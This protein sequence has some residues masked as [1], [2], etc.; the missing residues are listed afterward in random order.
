LQHESGEFFGQ[1]L[2]SSHTIVA[3]KLGFWLACHQVM[4]SDYKGMKQSV[5]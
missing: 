1:D 2:F 5:K 4:I 3:T